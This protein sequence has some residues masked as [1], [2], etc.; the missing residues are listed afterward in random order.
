M[1]VDESGDIFI[2]ALGQIFQ[3]FSFF[4]LDSA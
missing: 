4:L 2:N 1:P 3:M